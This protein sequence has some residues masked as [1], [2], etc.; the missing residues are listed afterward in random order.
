MPRLTKRKP[1]EHVNC[2]HCGADMVYCMGPAPNVPVDTYF[3]QCRNP[4]KA[5]WPQRIGEICYRNIP[6]VSSES[7]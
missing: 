7:P 1:L 4:E 3:A 2:E 5:I 6:R